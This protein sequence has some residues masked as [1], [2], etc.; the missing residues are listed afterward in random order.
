MKKE[1]ER[2]R[3]QTSSE[4]LT[5]EK[6]NEQINSRI[7][8][9]QQE[10]SNGFDFVKKC[11]KSITVF[12]SARTLPDEYDY[13]MA[14]EL[15][16]RVAK[17]LDYAVITGG[18]PG[19][20][21]AA[22]RGAHEAGGK[23]L[24]LTIKLPMEQV[25]NPYLTD[26]LDFDYF[27][28]RKV[29]MSFSAETYVYF[30]GGYGTLDELFEILTLVQTEKIEPTPIILFGKKYWKNLDKFIKKNLLKGDFAKIDE[31]DLDL[32]TITDSIDEALEI[33]KNAPIRLGTE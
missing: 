14:R 29:S 25:T 6:L 4:V 1:S 32:Y 5:L 23:S 12:G 2:P 10:F 13:K 26:H 8:R 21:E 31:K 24:G 17:E 7:D 3:K 22:N 9:I 15:G 16:Y 33:I 19:V 20:M 18:G 27:F 11:S 30:P 28:S